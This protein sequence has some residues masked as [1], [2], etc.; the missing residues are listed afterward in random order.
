M[1]AREA[2]S[3]AIERFPKLLDRIDDPEDLLASPHMVYSLLAEELLTNKTNQ[4]LIEATS[5][6]INELANSGD[7][8]LEEL[9]VI[10]VLEGLAQDP[11]LAKTMSM[12]IN[13]AAAKFLQRVEV[14]YFGRKLR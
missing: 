6:F 8:L 12:R 5:Q 10:D 14:E 9:L 13:P 11:H 2:I 1:T 7:D 4:A 3:L